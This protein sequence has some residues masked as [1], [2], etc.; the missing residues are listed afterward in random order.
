MKVDTIMDDMGI[1]SSRISAGTSDSGADMV[2][3]IQTIIQLMKKRRVPYGAHGRQKV[4]SN[5]W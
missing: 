1:T 4:L 3:G 5:A 2:K